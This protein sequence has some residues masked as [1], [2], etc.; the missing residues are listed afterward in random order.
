MGKGSGPRSGPTRPSP[1]RKADPVSGVGA[2]IPPASLFISAYNR[3]TTQGLLRSYRTIDTEQTT[4]KGRICWQKQA[5]RPAPLPIAVRYQIHDDDIIENQ[6]LRAAAVVLRR[7]RLTDPTT[8]TA[9]VRIW[10][11]LRDL[12][13][14]HVDRLPR[15]R[16]N[17]H[18][19]PILKLARTII[20]GSMA[21]VAPGDLPVT[22]FTIRLHN[23]FEQ[24]VR[25]ALREATDTTHHQFPDNPADHRLVLDDASRVRLEPDLGIRDGQN[26]RWVGDVKYKKDTRAGHNPDLYQLFAYATATNL[27]TA[28]LIYA[29]GPPTDTIP[30]QQHQ[31]D[32]PLLSPQPRPITQLRTA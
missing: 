11:Q 3:T 14:R 6:I 24:F 21:D 30:H 19:Q 18:Y 29:D 10:Q 7:Q 4:I 15:T 1:S 17:A 2:A 26:W 16:H 13:P 23:V 31:S 25:T 28:S 12:T 32:A 20:E 27:E 5:R 8:R 22:G 9:L